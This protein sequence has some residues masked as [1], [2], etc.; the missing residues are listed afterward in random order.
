MP[1]SEHEQ[2]ILAELE[3]SLV[4]HD[5]SFANKVRNEGV[6]RHAGR[7][8]KWGVLGFL[9]GLGILVG[10]FTISIWL[11]FLGVIIMFASA[12]VIHRSM[13]TMG[14]ASWNDITRSLSEDE[15]SGASGIE[16]H[17]HEARDWFRGRFNQRPEA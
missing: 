14:R 10:C 8:T 11:G 7:Q 2:K 3:E 12:V 13:A 5:P 9:V 16:N 17:I 6:Y 15:P 4:R 1:L